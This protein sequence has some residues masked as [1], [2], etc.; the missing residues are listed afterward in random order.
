MHTIQGATVK[1]M[2]ILPPKKRVFIIHGWGGF[3]GEGWFPWLKNELEEKG[4]EVQIPSMPNASHPK[5]EEWLPALSSAI[6]IPDGSTYLVGH[7]L[8]CAAILQYLQ[9][10]P[11]NVTIGGAVLVAPVAGVESITNRINEVAG[12]HDVLDSWIHTPMDWSVIK[13]NARHI[14]GIFSDNDMWIRTE[15]ADMFREKLN[16]MTF[17]LHDHLHFSGDDNITELPEALE[18]LLHMSSR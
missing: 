6:G 4:F 14:V 17:L 3:S 18:A 8:G 5:K 10:L 9:S 1:F 15:T 16:A 11:G 7:S 13:N 2:S 12:A